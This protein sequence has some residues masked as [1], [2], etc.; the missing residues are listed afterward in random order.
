MPPSS[1][2]TSPWLAPPVQGNKHL[3]AAVL[4]AEGGICVVAV[5]LNALLELAAWIV[6]H[7]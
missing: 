3:P 7:L 1:L 4:P 5:L 6:L 2:V